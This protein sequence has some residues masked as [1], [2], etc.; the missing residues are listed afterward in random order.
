VPPEAG[1][2]APIRFVGEEQRATVHAVVPIGDGCSRQFEIRFAVGK[3]GRLPFSVGSALELRLPTGAQRSAADRSTQRDRVR[4]HT[5][6]RD[7]VC[8]EGVSRVARN[9]IR[10][11]GRYLVEIRTRA[12]ERNRLV[13][14]DAEDL[15]P[16]QAIA[17]A[18]PA[19][20]TSLIN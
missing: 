12:G 3:S 8:A 13:V 1:Q 5:H 11:R 2:A 18:R 20:G 6:L 17:V 9:R 14:R 10:Q 7:A 19:A 15:K 4:A 16:G